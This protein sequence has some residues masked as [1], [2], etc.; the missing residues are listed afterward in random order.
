MQRHVDTNSHT[1]QHY[2]FLSGSDSGGA[3]GIAYLST[4][5][6]RAGRGKLNYGM[7]HISNN[8]YVVKNKLIVQDIFILPVDQKYKTSIN[9]WYNNVADSAGVLAHE[10]GHALGMSHDFGSGGTS[11]TRYD[12]QGNS[13]TGINGL[14]DYGARRNVNKFSTCSK[15]DFAKFHNQMVSRYGSF[16]L[17]TT[18][19]KLIVLTSLLLL[20]RC[21]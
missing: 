16:C 10:L 5:C 14:M 7:L 8:N 13:C 1:T 3:I 19:C 11:D 20:F 2:A 6:L 15:E 18:C 12:S 21:K 4:P 9:E 17:P